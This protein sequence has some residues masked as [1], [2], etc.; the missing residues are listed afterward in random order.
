MTNNP[1]A[2]A[3]P[4]RALTLELTKGCNLRCGY[5]YYAAREDAYDPA[6][7]M[8]PAVAERSIELLLTEGPADQPV[9]LHL[10][11]GEPLLNFKLVEHV[12]TYGERRAR[13]E[14]RTITFELTTNGTR[15][16]DRIIEF[17]NEHSIQVGVSF[18]GP[19]QVQDESRPALKG[20][21]Y[22]L[23]EAGIRKFLASRQ[24]TELMVKTH[25]SVVV[26]RRELDLVAIVEHLEGMGF[27]SVILTPATDLSGQ[28][29]G[30]TESDL[31][32]ILAAYD[33][34]A[35]RYER[36]RR[37]GQPTSVLW[38]DNL[39]DR[40]LSGQRK[41]RFCGGGVDYLGVSSD[42]SMSLC[43]RFYQDED[44]GMGD[45][46]DGIDRTV[47]KKLED[48]G[49]ENRLTCGTCWARYF[50]GGGCH[51]EN[52]IATGSLGEP[53]PIT[54]EIL[55][56]S[57]DHTLEIFGRESSRGAVAQI[58]SVA[59]TSE[60]QMTPDLEI[61][62]TDT[63]AAKPTC[64]IREVGEERVVYEP[65]VHEVAFLNKTATWLFEQC[66]GT[67]SVQDLLTAM[68]ARFDA[69][70]DVLRQDLLD[71]IGLFQSRG[72]LT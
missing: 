4:P 53:N 65:G 7:T 70:E 44:F 15:F 25:C 46:F 24:G 34:L 2:L 16:S 64:H 59:N 48:E 41:T 12:V 9:H 20:S 8:S 22:A 17:L 23:A 1:P 66:D 61:K 31:P 36:R 11:G 49:L 10:F 40:L 47:T 3:I 39:M 71:T 63:P 26:T 5:C 19:P 28:S 69:P 62:M 27:E 67:R 42:G 54:C 43:Y 72:L 33:A 51:H 6:T 32:A 21:S 55:R 68:V 45:V 37:D 52:L 57:M 18:D 56:H 60:E 29:H 13:E 58:P 50:C 14:S 35:E 38:Y 30:L